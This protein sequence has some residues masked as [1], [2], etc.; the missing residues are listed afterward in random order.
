MASGTPLIETIIEDV[1]TDLGAISIANGFRTTPATVSRKFRN[2]DELSE[3]DYPALFLA[4]GDE[5]IIDET[6]LEINSMHQFVII[7]YVRF[8][9]HQAIGEIA[10]TQLIRLI[11][12]VKE[13]LYAD[14]TR[15]D[16]AVN[17]YIRSVETDEGMFEPIAIFRM[18][19]ELEYE[20]YGTDT[21]KR[22]N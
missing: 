20:Y 12:D 11:A 21:T 14:R 8:S 17:T 3:S 16:N 1:L 6:N 18:V 13:K 9:E 5:V 22:F 15:G 4:S 19:A 7:G 2:W 10:S